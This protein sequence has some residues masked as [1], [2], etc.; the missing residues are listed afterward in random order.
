[1]TNRTITSSELQ[2][3]LDII[4]E[5]ESRTVQ[6]RNP[7]IPVEI[8]IK[9]AKA[10]AMSVIN[11]IK[12]ADGGKMSAEDASKLMNTAISSL[13][14]VEQLSAAKYAIRAANA[15]GVKFAANTVKYCPP[16]GLDAALANNV[17]F[18]KGYRIIRRAISGQA[19]VVLFPWS[20]STTK[21]AC[22]VF[23]APV[24]GEARL[25]PNE[26]L[27]EDDL[28]RLRLL[29]FNTDSKTGDLF[30]LTA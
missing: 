11:A 3:M 6:A 10:S 28:I 27:S 29:G 15:H 24:N 13:K 14:G 30:F 19:E 9:A 8:I 12:Y 7:A 16:K 21:D 5:V 1:M 26:V 22:S 20:A 17:E 18:H 23:L 2:V 25:R 4:A